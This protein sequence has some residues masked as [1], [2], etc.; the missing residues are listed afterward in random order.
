MKLSDTNYIVGSAFAGPN[1]ESRHKQE[2]LKR[3]DRKTK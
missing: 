3:K 1:V 2:A